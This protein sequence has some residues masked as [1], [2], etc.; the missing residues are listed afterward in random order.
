MVE[1]LGVVTLKADW[2]APNDEIASMLKKLGSKQLPVLAIF[3][4]KNPRKPIVLRGM[5]SKKTLIDKL[6]EA[7]P[8]KKVARNK[9][10][11]QQ[12]K[13]KKKKKTAPPKG[14][15]NATSAQG[16]P[17]AALAEQRRRSG[18]KQ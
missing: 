15:P 9:Q 18:V 16:T 13:K 5:Y 8:S 10:Q 14:R 4:A 12:Q 7:G 6:R 17:E 2:T 3:P 1:E 11:K